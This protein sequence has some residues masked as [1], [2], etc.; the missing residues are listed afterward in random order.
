MGLPYNADPSTREFTTEILDEANRRDILKLLVDFLFSKGV[1]E[2]RVEFGYVQRLELR[3]KPQGDN[4][5]VL[6]S[7]LPSF[8]ERGLE[9]GTIEWNGMSDFFFSPIGID[10]RFMLCN[11]AD[12]HF[13]STDSVLLM[14]L[15]RLLASAGIKVYD[16]GNLISG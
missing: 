9:E 13:A 4:Q 2:V 3:G 5:V 10:L 7:D 15:G 6:L 14:E 11:D 1:K 16:S 12:L 8:I